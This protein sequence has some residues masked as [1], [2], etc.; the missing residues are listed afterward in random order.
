MTRQ[1]DTFRKYLNCFSMIANEWTLYDIHLLANYY[2]PDTRVLDPIVSLKSI[3][4]FGEYN[5]VDE[6]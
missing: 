5:S 3:R 6:I 1:T 4:S 2:F